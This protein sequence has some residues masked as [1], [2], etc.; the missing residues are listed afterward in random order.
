[1]AATRGCISRGT[2]LRRMM[3]TLALI[4]LILFPGAQVFADG[5]TRTDDQVRE[6]LIEKS[7]ASYPGSCPCPYN[8]AKNGSRCGKRS[9]WSRAGGYALLCYPNEVTDAMVKRYRE[10]HEGKSEALP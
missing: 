9:A 5:H 3:A 7:I 6:A 4:S 1:M 8:A 10:Q 2:M